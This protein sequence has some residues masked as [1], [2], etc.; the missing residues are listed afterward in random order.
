MCEP[1]QLF[2]EVLHS[3]VSLTELEKSFEERIEEDELIERKLELV[4]QRNKIVD[5][6]DED[7]L[8]YRR[9]QVFF[10]SISLVIFVLLD[11]FFKEKILSPTCSIM[12]LTFR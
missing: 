3:T 8:R 4:S 1:V 9:K 7:R 6:I 12:T 10:V 5:S 11:R 2:E